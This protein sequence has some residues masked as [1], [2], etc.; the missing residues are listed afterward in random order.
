MYINF[1][2]SGRPA[3]ALKWTMTMAYTRSPYNVREED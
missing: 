2:Y 3:N 1:L